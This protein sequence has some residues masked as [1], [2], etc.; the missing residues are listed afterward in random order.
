MFGASA[1]SCTKDNGGARR[2]LRGSPAEQW[3]NAGKMQW[4]AS[5]LRRS[6]TAGGSRGGYFELFAPG[7]E[8][9]CCD[10]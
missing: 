9:I 10:M 5:S 3:A 6:P 7:S 1:K 8:A 2:D 4:I